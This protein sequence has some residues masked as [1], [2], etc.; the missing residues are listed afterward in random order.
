MCVF[1]VLFTTTNPLWK[2]NGCSILSMMR[3]QGIWQ[4]GEEFQELRMLILDSYLHRK[5]AGT[6]GMVP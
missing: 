2:K 5:N 1:N 6:L 3:D 4:E